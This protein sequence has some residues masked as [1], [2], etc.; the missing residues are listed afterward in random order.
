[1]TI[2][3]SGATAVT[4]LPNISDQAEHVTMVQRTPTYIGIK[5]DKNVILTT[6]NKLFSPELATKINRWINVILM[7]LTYQLCVRFPNAARRTVEGMMFKQVKTV[8]TREEFAKHF[9]PPYT[10]WQQ[11]FCLAPEGDFFR[12]IRYTMIFYRTLPPAQ[13]GLRGREPYA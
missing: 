9:S 13:G 6:L 2:I 4:L 5:P 12:A 10:P 3:G 11:R 7:V 1:M 8:M